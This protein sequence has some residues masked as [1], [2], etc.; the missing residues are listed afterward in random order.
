MKYRFSALP[1]KL[2]ALLLVL[3]SLTFGFLGGYTTAW[4]LAGGYYVQDAV[5]QTSTSCYYLAQSE[6]DTVFA[7]FR[8]D[9]GYDR[10]NILLEDNSFR[11]V[12]LEEE[13]GVVR[14]AYVEGLDLDPSQSFAENKY[15]YRE[16]FPMSLGDP[17]TPFEGLYV[18]DAYFHGPSVEDPET[19]ISYQVLCLLPAALTDTPNDPFAQ[20][21]RQ[22]DLLHDL[23]IKG[24]VLLGICAAVLTAA[25]AFLLCQAGRRP[26]RE[27]VTLRWFDRIPLDVMAVGAF[28]AVMLL[29]SLVSEFFYVI[30]YN[31][32][33]NNNFETGLS[34]A[35]TTLIFVC[36]S[37]LILAFFCTL[38][39]RVKAGNWWKTFLLVRLA[40]WLL[41]QLGQ[42][43]R[44][45]LRGIRAIALA[46]RAALAV[47]AA[48]FV[49]FVLM[50]LFIESPDRF[51]YFFLLAVYNLLLLL[52]TIL[53]AKQLVTLR[54]AG[55]QLAAGD[56][57]HQLNTDKLFWDFK[58]HGENLNA[59]A[60]GMNKAVDQRMR[61]E[62]LKT[63]LITNV[64][65]DIK[66]P[67]TSIVNYVD[68]L[69]KP[70]SD[71]EGARYLEVLDRQA[72][73]LKKL[74]E[75][76]V[77]ASKASTGNLPV[78]LVPTSVSELVNQAVEEYRSRLEAGKLEVVVSLQPDLNVLADGKLLW[79]VLDNLLG[80][81]VKYALA[82]T[83]VYVT[84]VLWEPDVVIA[85]K[86]ISREP[87]NVSA[88]ELMERFVRGDTAR[89]SEGSGLGLNIAQS[90]TQ[91]Q[92]GRF[93]LTVDG[94]LFKAEVFLPQAKPAADRTT[95]HFPRAPET[96]PPGP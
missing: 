53:G 13:S 68:L 60:E 52:V 57:T 21:Q 84:A 16:D 83:R 66:T 85:V 74:T 92:H 9:P 58:R 70:H 37:L 24:P 2:L 90:L 4:C 20:G 38:A 6:A 34:L 44:W 91:L 65:H 32:T 35:G 40:L 73:R 79:R 12:L 59:I 88:D 89:H 18:T 39:T 94:D 56:L 81:V 8:T 63:E 62:R 33:Y 51:L 82:G 69:Q 15:L 67:L 47:T 10:W 7:R 11:F 78:A 41:R 42:F 80:N 87:L 17:D 14:A 48:L 45:A 27:G 54:K 30:S 96:F 43:L 23:R 1:W 55:E 77:E 25:V 93:Q 71:E 22:F 75:D 95:D 50:L 28:L 64:S 31:Y 26:G 72:K 49:E 5:Y 29:S 76:L 3:L 36:A 46:P 86:N 61:S 19:E